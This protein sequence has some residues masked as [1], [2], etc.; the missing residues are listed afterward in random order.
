MLHNYF[1]VTLEQ[2]AIFYKKDQ[3]DEFNKEKV[4]LNY[5][6]IIE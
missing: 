3:I 6:E 5:F 2:G 1:V 4:W